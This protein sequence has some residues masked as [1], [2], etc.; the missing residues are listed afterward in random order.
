MA[1]QRD[2]EAHPPVL[3]SVWT[4]R[5]QHIHAVARVGRRRSS[6]VVKPMSDGVNGTAAC[7]FCSATF[8]IKDQPGLIA[9]W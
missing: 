9:H 6:K 4:L 8:T 3:P 1:L 2:L 7:Y 5:P